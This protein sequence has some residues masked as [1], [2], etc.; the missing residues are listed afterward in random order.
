MQKSL[1]ISRHRFEPEV[2]RVV[3]GETI[4]IHNHSRENHTV[5]ADNGTFDSDIIGPTESIA[6]EIT[7]EIPLGENLYHCT[8]NEEMKGALDVREADADP[9]IEEEAE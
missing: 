7:D 9:L 6:L 4:M 2:L 3:R 1:N 8:V 5:T